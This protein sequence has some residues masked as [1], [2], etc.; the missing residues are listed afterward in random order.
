VGLIL[1]LI[2]ASNLYG[3][4]VGIISG[5][6]VDEKGEPIKDVLIR[7][8]GMGGGRKYKVKTNKKGKFI[9]AAVSFQDDYRV[10]ASKEGYQTQYWEGVTPGFTRD[11]EDSVVDF[12]LQEGRSGRLQFEMTKEELEAE[13]RKQAEIARKAALAEA[14][15]LDF[16][17]GINFFKSG[18]YPQAADSFQRVV[19]AD[20]NQVSAWSNLGSCYSKM[21]Q[22]DKALEAYDRAIELDPQNPKHYRMKG[23]IYSA[24]GDTEKAQEQYAKASSIGETGDRHE[25]AVG[26]YN[27]GITYI[28]EGKLRDALE[29]L[30]KAVEMDP[31]HAESHYQLGLTFLGMNDVTKAVETLRKYVEIAPNSENASV[32]KELIKEL[33]G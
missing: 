26:F 31:T 4:T 14:I 15:Q 28:N 3:P 1:L 29:A 24:L 32:A 20:A 6:V 21:N 23:S 9:H 11:Q 27:M 13:K 30:Q 16:D 22:H 10:I 19:E 2:P 33:G 18:K 8:E 17:Q 25:A 7:I 5:K 12:V